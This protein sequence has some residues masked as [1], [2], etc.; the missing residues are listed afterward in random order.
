MQLTE[1][2]RPNSFLIEFF[3]GFFRVRVHFRT[4]LFE[5]PL[6]RAAVAFLNASASNDEKRE[7]RGAA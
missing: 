4:P 7:M 5:A 1:N 6:L 3:R 2:K